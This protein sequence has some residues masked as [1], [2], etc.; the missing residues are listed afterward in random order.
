VQSELS[1]T[2]HL[3]AIGWVTA[4]KD[5]YDR[6]S[7]SDQKLIVAAMGQA[8]SWAT[9]KMK[10]SESE[11]LN[12]LQAAGMRITRPDAAAIRDK[13]KGA[14]E[15]LFKTAWPVTTWAEVLAQ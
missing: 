5:F 14:V 1:L 7:L 10:A 12:Q 2:N 15:E 9:E 8:C 3:V 4:N 6:L 11:L 13:A